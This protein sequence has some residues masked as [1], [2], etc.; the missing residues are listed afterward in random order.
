V[1]GAT[2]SIHRNVKGVA[3]NIH[4]V[5]LDPNH[6]YTVWIFEVNCG[7][8]SCLPV[9]LAGHIVGESGVASF[10]GH[11][12]LNSD[13]SRPVQDPFGGEFHA[14]IADHGPLDPSDLPN[15]IK[16]PVPPFSPD[17]TQNWEQVVIFAP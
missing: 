1:E 10:S 9:Q 16:S 2:A 12:G 7:A 8:S 17:G 4:T 14:I 11:L 15:A 13:S 3:I 6:V 5:G